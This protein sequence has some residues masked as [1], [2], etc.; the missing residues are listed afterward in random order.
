MKFRYIVML[1]FFMLVMNWRILYNSDLV[2]IV[3]KQACQAEWDRY[4]Q[5]HLAWM[6]PLDQ[7]N[8]KWFQPGQYQRN[9]GPAVACKTTRWQS[10]INLLQAE[11]EKKCNDR[12][13]GLKLIS[14]HEEVI[15]LLG[16]TTMSWAL[17]LAL[18]C[19]I[20]AKFEY[21]ILK[22]ATTARKNIS[23]FF[24]AIRAIAPKE[25]PR[26]RIKINR[27]EVRELVL[28]GLFSSFL[29]WGVLYNFDSAETIARQFCW[30]DWGKYCRENS[31]DWLKTRR[32]TTMGELEEKYNL[33]AAWKKQ[34]WQN[35]NSLCLE[36]AQRGCDDREYVL[37][38]Y[39]IPNSWFPVLMINI[40]VVCAICS[41]G[42]GL[43]A[44]FQYMVERY[45]WDKRCDGA[46]EQ[47]I[48]RVAQPGLIQGESAR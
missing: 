5:Q 38:H 45:G 30:A 22:L 47:E 15:M 2:G 14:L 28:I 11:S 36:E 6:K 31:A 42:K 17:I 19:I 10:V 39:F 3:I 1:W 4:Y 27:T 13:Y 46:I 37:Q 40:I 18:I 43:S 32:K 33:T 35:I 12:E 25:A 48:E 26:I 34:Y 23:E 16:Y 8:E 29:I 44:D 21:N 24:T 41:L 9:G 20:W 7:S